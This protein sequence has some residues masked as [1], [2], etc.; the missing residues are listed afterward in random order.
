MGW[1][2]WTEYQKCPL[3]F[4]ILCGYIDKVYFYLLTYIY[5]QKL[6]PAFL[7]V[8]KFDVKLESGGMIFK[9]TMFTWFFKNHTKSKLFQKHIRQRAFFQ[10]LMSSWGVGE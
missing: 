1:G 7:W 4:F 10:N 6:S 2:G 9:I 8:S 5:S 3:S